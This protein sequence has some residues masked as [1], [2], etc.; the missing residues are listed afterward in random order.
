MPQVLYTMISS[1]LRQ[2]EVFVSTPGIG[3]TGFVFAWNF[4]D[5]I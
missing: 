5:F 4:M 2:P 1:L 3:T